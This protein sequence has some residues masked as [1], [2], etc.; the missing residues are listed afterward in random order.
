[1][2]AFFERKK[3]FKSA[4]QCYVEAK[5]LF[6]ELNEQLKNIKSQRDLKVCYNNISKLYEFVGDKKEAQLYSIM[7]LELANKIALETNSNIDM[8][9]LAEAF[10]NYAQIS[11]DA[12]GYK[13]A[14]KIWNF[15]CDDCP[16]IEEYK[17][18]K[19]M[20]FKILED[21]D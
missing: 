15:L 17:E 5:N 21:L 4:E 14:Y 9:S 16:D 3:H 19:N 8:E 18:N 7:A 6:E 2:K 13:S 12:E 11:Q 10:F 1:M 20:V